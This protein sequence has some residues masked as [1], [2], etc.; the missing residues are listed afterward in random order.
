MILFF[1]KKGTAKRGLRRKGRIGVR[2]LFYFSA[3]MAVVFTV[4][5]F[6]F[7]LAIDN[8]I[9]HQSTDKLAAIMA[10]LDRDPAGSA[11]PSFR[12]DNDA[13]A[14]T[15]GANPLVPGLTD[16]ATMDLLRRGSSNRDVEALIAHKDFALVFPN[17]DNDLLM[18]V[19]SMKAMLAAMQRE[20]AGFTDGIVTRVQTG[21]GVYYVDVKTLTAPASSAPA[22]KLVLFI[23]TDRYQ[24]L[25]RSIDTVLLF[26]VLL[27]FGGSVVASLMLARGF[28]RP[29]RQLTDF[30]RALGQGDFDRRPFDF[31]DREIA[32]L[33]D[34]MNQTAERLGAYDKEQKTFFQ[35]VSHELRT[36][37]MSIQGYA[38]GIRYGVFPDNAEAADIIVDESRRL[39][40]MVED[41]LYLSRMDAAPALDDAFPADLREVLEDTAER[42]AGLALQLGKTI[43][44]DLPGQP[45]VTRC[46]TG[47]IGRAVGNLLSN[48][49]RYASKTVTLSCRATGETAV[50]EVAD[51]GGGITGEDLPHLFERFY[52]GKSGHHGI[53][54]AIVKS[55][56]E[57]HGG[58][59]QARNRPEGGAAFTLELPVRS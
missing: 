33:G 50:L 11:V 51:D 38:E 37:L 15:I 25:I 7:N 47:A 21:D 58:T 10:G 18:D 8:Y 2:L 6:L 31:R 54:L 23:H 39:T 36:P 16:R 55:V 26:I 52:K 34:H 41:L 53:G 1:G 5:F 12:P 40:G 20:S 32:E 42:L 4:L 57:Q 49:L 30:A 45:V 43:R 59:V 28:S 3:T 56:A 29:L 46:D 17:E 35:N 19:A 27:A 14:G 24:E 13:P 48:G 22:A 9:R 44:L